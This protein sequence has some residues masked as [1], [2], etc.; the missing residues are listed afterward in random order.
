V[1]AGIDTNPFSKTSI[2]KKPLS[3]DM[4]R[5]ALSAEYVA[6]LKRQISTYFGNAT[7]NTGD[8]SIATYTAEPDTPRVAVKFSNCQ[9]K[10][11]TVQAGLMEQIGQVPIP[12][13]AKPPTGTDHAM[14]IWQ[15]S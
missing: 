7:V 15:P 10:S 5:D 2:W 14:I 3:T 13:D 1:T 12:S 11:D 4:H 8:Y 9:N 6:S